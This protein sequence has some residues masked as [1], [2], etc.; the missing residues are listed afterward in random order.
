VLLGKGR[1]A[2]A[3]EAK[4]IAMIDAA[5]STPPPRA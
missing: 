2:E 4:L 5:R 3:E 1:T